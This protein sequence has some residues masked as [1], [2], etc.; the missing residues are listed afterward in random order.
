[1]HWCIAYPCRDQEDQAQMCSSRA[2]WSCALKIGGSESFLTIS[3]PLALSWK[4][5]LFPTTLPS[6][7]RG[8]RSLR[9]TV[10]P[11]STPQAPRS[12]TSGVI[13]PREDEAYTSPDVVYGHVA[14]EFPALE[15][16]R[17][18]LEGKAVALGGPGPVGSL[19]H[20]GGTASRA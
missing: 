1:M 11:L 19:S 5:L 10:F 7:P 8:L 15:Y 12:H 18:L 13:C 20:S 3:R 16:P 9:C 14:R 2:S 6:L 4:S 17:C